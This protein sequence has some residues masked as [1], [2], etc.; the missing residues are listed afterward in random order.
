MTGRA[1]AAFGLLRGPWAARARDAVLAAG[2]IACCVG[3]VAMTGPAGS[4]SVFVPLLALAAA[5]AGRASAEHRAVP[6][7]LGG[8]LVWCLARALLEAQVWSGVAGAVITVMFGVLPWLVG[9]YLRQ[10]GALLDAGWQRAESLEREL[11]AVSEQERLRERA[12]IAEEMHDLLGHELSLMAV[13]AGALEVGPRPDDDEFRRAAGDLRA[14]ATAATDRLQAIVGVLDG[15]DGGDGGGARTS[16]ADPETSAPAPK[17]ARAPSGGI[18]GLVRRAAAAGMA[19][20]WDGAEPRGP[21]PV[22]RLAEAVVREALT[23]AAKH[24]P[25]ARVRVTLATR[26]R[27]ARAEGAAP[28]AGAVSGASAA[29]AVRAVFA[30]P[31]DRVTR[32]SGE[33]AV[34]VVNGTAPHTG[35]G[36]D[37]TAAPGAPSLAGGGRGLEWLDE[38]VR[39]AG[40]TL[41][42]GPCG[43]SGFRVAARLPTAR[44]G[45]RPRGTARAPVADT[46]PRRP[47]EPVSVLLVCVG[48]LAPLLVTWYAYAAH[49]ERSAGLGSAEYA[50]IQVGQPRAQAEAVLP[51]GSLPGNVFV[52]DALRGAGGGGPP[53]A[54]SFYRSRLGPAWSPAFTYRVCYRDGRVVAKCAYNQAR[55]ITADGL[56]CQTAAEA[57]PGGRSTGHGTGG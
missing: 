23:N 22:V 49:L 43:D 10:R 35:S 57:A 34:C 9:R 48:L 55:R 6:L 12:R 15:G 52:P 8:T 13:R 41:E 54:C 1:A 7:W 47:H 28:A 39:A 36:S 42:S 26:L 51:E 33:T 45:V 27:P 3:A 17:S 32:R 25:G 40:G 24:A 53:P 31:F 44:A 21:E 19:V 38:R 5:A 18:A 11:A 4:A 16:G 20:D 14:G 29:S 56:R 37:A 2:V 46:R 30:A 50:R